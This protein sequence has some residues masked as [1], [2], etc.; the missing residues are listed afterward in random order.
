MQ[1]FSPSGVKKIEP[2]KN[3]M[4]RSDE[5]IEEQIRR[6]LAVHDDL[7]KLQVSPLF[8][9]HL[10]QR[11]DTE[12]NRKAGT[13]AIRGTEGFNIKL[14]FAVMLLVINI[15]ST[16]LFFSSS[17]QLKL[18]DAADALEQ[19]TDDYSR[20][21]LAYYVETADAAGSQHTDEQNPQEDNRP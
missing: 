21:E 20:P 17:D 15:S 5:N 4:K 9:V 14:A 3:K 8:R 18:A 10:M 7:P 2:V 16:L 19:L 13:A 1:V 6:T 12:R 11:I